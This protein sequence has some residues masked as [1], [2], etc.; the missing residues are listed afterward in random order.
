MKMTH[1]IIHTKLFLNLLFA[2]GTASIAWA[3]GETATGQVNGQPSGSLYD[4]TI[5]LDNTSGSVSI[6]SFWYAWTPTI[7]PFF[8]LPSTPS[9]ASA[10]TGWTAS[11]A[12]NSIQYVSSGIPLAPGQSI[13]FQYVAAFSPSQLTGDAGYSYVYTGGIEGDPGALVNVQT[14]PEPASSVLFLAGFL[15]WVGRRWR[16]PKAAGVGQNHV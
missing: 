6:G 11:I 7:S 1:K 14:V 16:L 15:G 2:L 13:Q 8:Y 10:P 5:T 9:S 3:Q 12:A 4:Y